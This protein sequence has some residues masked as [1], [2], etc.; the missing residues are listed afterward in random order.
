MPHHVVGFFENQDSGGVLVGVAAVADSTLNVAG[1]NVAV[2]V[3]ADKLAGVGG[4]GATITLCRV[5]SP[6]LD[7]LVE[8]DVAPLNL[9]AEPAVPTPWQNMFNAPR[10]L[11]E[12]EN[13]SVEV[14]E[15]AAGA[16]DEY[17]VVFLTS[18]K[19]ALP[20]GEIFTVRATGATT[21]TADV[22]T[23]CPLTFGQTLPAGRY[24]IV[25]AHVVSATGIAY[26]FNISGQAQ[27]PGGFAYDAVSDM[28]DAIFRKGGLGNWGEF[29]HNVPPQLEMLCTAADTAQAVYLDLIK[30]G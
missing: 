1:D 19:V 5:N 25:G 4:I 9:A 28:P 6:E 12:S 15:A 16:E 3:W 22:W 17:V 27:R 21:V 26:R 23:N 24:A 13:M 2:P 20:S 11:K 8:E 30:V 14:A 18:G 29:E 7:R 10:Q